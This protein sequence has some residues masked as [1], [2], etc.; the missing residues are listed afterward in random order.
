MKVHFRLID[1]SDK[2][3][4]LFEVHQK[5]P[6]IEEMAVL[7][8]NYQEKMILVKDY[9]KNQDIQLKVT[10]VFYIEY[11]E[12][13]CFFYTVSKTYEKRIT[14][15]QL[16][17]NLPGEFLQISKTMIVNVLSVE[18]IKS[19]LLNGN[20]YCLLKNKEELMVSRHFSKSFKQAINSSNRQK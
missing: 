12:R 10:D 20:L 13:K 15:N 18:E 14:L 19:S 8:E 5:T 17:S 6:F 7:L 4:V 16:K 9:Q 1:S 2:E 11:I 3:N